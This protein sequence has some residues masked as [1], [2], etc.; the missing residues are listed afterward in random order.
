MN[1][2]AKPALPSMEQQMLDALARFKAI[3]N[4][5]EI[6]IGFE[7][8]HDHGSGYTTPYYYAERVD[9]LGIGRGS[10][11]MRAVNDL[12]KRLNISTVEQYIR[13]KEAGL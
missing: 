4:Q 3:I 8:V 2:I 6:V 12:I 5:G 1:A 7:I 10:T 13:C 9:E 11:P